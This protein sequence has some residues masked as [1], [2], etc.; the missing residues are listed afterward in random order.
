MI[1]IQKVKSDHYSFAVGI[2]VLDEDDNALYFPPLFSEK[3]FTIE[4]TYTY[5]AK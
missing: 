2:K 5:L 1:H 3:E 4:Q